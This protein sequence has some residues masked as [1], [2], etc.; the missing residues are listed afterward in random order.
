MIKPCV[1]SVVQELNNAPIAEKVV[2]AS[3]IACNNAIAAVRQL[4][5]KWY[6]HGVGID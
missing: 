3:V 6:V 4:T 2:L 1:G 5:K